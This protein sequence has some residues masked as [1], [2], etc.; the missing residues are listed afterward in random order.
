MLVNNEVADQGSDQH[1]GR[2]VQGGG[3]GLWDVTMLFH[4]ARFG[5]RGRGLGVQVLKN[6]F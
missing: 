5:F 1:P 3:V 6:W 2:G 4:F